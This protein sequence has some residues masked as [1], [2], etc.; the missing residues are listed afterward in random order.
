MS[1][2]AIAVGS[3]VAAQSGTAPRTVAGALIAAMLVVSVTGMLWRVVPTVVAPAFAWGALALLWPGLARPQRLQV[4]AFFAAG[5]AALLWGV[6]RG[7]ELRIESVLGQNQPIL[8]MLASI[9]LLRL[10]TPPVRE[11]EPE[12]PRGRS[13]YLRSMLGVHVF[14][15]VIN[16]SAVII[17][18]DRLARGA[19]LRMNQA[20]LLSRAFT[21]VAFYSPFI[22]GV[23]LALAYTPESNP[24]LMMVFGAALALVAL[25]LL[26]WYARSGR[27]EEVDDF[28]G[29]PVHLE[30]LWLPLVLAGAVLLASAVTSGYSVLS[31]ITMMTPVVVGMALLVSDGPRGLGRSLSGYVHQRLPEMRGEL[32]LFLGAGVLGAGLVAAFS[33]TDGWLPFVRFD[34]FTA[35]VLLVVFVLTSLLCVHPVVVVSVVA[36]LVL[37]IA[38]DQTLLA[39]TFAMGWGLGCAVNPMSGTNLILGT[40]YGVSNWAIGRSNIAFSATLF[41]FAVA[42]IYLYQYTVV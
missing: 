29:Y 26:A 40:R 24:A 6:S 2:T 8:S 16:I 36:P 42:L 34:A 23:A 33:S 13:T 5:I 1:E 18:A 25:M 19:P 27:V 20:K 3:P 12:L 21:A 7:A 39:I 17:M 32:A 9:S 37:P 41:F 30:V 22:G 15:A 10:L 4:S 28:R 31:L 11:G 38:P 35:S 14:G